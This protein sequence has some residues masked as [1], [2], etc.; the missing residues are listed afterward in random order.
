MWVIFRPLQ[1]RG[2]RAEG[3]SDAEIA[4]VGDVGSLEGQKRKRKNMRNQ[5]GITEGAARVRRT[6]VRRLGKE[7]TNLYAGKVHVGDIRVKKQSVRIV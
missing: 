1:E 4:S 7:Q 6:G 2:E 5:N 3:A